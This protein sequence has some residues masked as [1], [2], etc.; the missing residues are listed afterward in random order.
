MKS[1]CNNTIMV[2]ERCLLLQTKNCT[3]KGLEGQRGIVGGA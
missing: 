2:Y 3:I 1:I